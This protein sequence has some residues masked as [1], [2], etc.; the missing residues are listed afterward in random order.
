MSPG[1]G[2]CGGGPR[3]LRRL[4]HPRAG[5]PTLTAPGGGFKKQGGAY[6]LAWSRGR[7]QIV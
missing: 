4:F 5:P 1:E 6:P 7:E 3:P 2:V